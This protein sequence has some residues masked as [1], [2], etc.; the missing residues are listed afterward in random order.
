MSCEMCERP[1]AG[2]DY[3]CAGCSRDLAE[4]LGQ[5]PGLYVAL[6]GML[7]PGRAADSSGR[8]AAAVEVPL[9]VRTDVV[10]A[11]AEFAVLEVWARALA[12]D[13]GVAH[14]VARPV[15]E[16]LGSRVQAASGALRVAVWWI[17]SVWPAA[18]DCAREVRDLYDS[19]RSVVGA[20]DLP[21][22]M[23]R[24]PQQ[25]HG[26]PCGAELL[27]P[28]GVQVLRCPWCG[29]TY[30]PGVWAALKVAQRAMPAT[31]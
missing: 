6:G 10:D 30:P 13:Q 18:G 17:A 16:E 20:A 1:A 24:C 25:V 19:A 22:R 9:P 28:Q 4:R 3:L 12:A 7:A 31:A 14:P 21:A 11:R 2:D 5:L 8:A 23:G 27:L 15:T 26:E 29:A